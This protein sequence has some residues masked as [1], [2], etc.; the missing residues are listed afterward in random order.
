MKNTEYK[1]TFKAV[2]MQEVVELCVAY[3]INKMERIESL[4]GMYDVI[5]DVSMSFMVKNLKEFEDCY[6]VFVTGEHDERI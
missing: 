4:G 2:D 6:E 5:A 3:W 1:I